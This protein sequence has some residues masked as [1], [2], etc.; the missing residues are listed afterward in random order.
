MAQPTPYDRQFSFQDFQAQ[1]PTTPLPGDEVDGELNAV[2][3][4]IDQTLVNLA[5]IQRDD[6]A[7]KNGIV[8]QDALSDSLSIGFTLRGEWQSGVNYYLGDGVTV[9]SKFFRATASALS[10]AG[11]APEQV[12]APWVVVANFTQATED[13]EAAAAAALVSEN[14]AAASAA[15]AL[16]SENAAAASADAAS[17]SA[18]A[19]AASE[20]SAADSAADAADSA[21]EAA[22]L[23]TGTVTQAVRWDVAQSLSNPEQE[24]A[25]GNIGFLTNVK[26]GLIAQVGASARARS[27]QDSYREDVTVTAQAH[28]DPTD[29]GIQQAI[30]RAIDAV[31]ARGANGGRVVIP[32][33]GSNY[34]LTGKIILKDNIILEGDGMP[35]LRLADSVNT[36]MIEGDNFLTLSGTNSGSGVDG[37]GLRNLI[38]DGNRTNNVSP[39]A[40]EGH[41]IAIYGRDFTI[42]TVEVIGAYRRGVHLEYGNTLAGVSPYNGGVFDLLVNGT[43]EEGFW[44]SV[45]DI[46]CQS[47]NLRTN[48]QN[49]DN[50]Y[51]AVYLAVGIRVTNM[52]VWMGGSSGVYHRYSLNLAGPGSTIVGAHLEAAKTAS[53]IITGAGNYLSGIDSYNLLGDDHIIVDSSRNYIRAQVFNGGQPVENINARSVR[54]INGRIGNDISVEVGGARGAV[55]AFDSVGGCSKFVANGFQAT[56]PVLFTGKPHATDTVD[57]TITGGDQASFSKKAGGSSSIAGIGSTQAGAAPINRAA[58]RLFPNGANAAFVLPPAVTGAMI[59]VSNVGG[60]GATIFPNTGDNH[61]GSAANDSVNLAAGSQAIYFAHSNTEWISIS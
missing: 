38:L 32:N 51:D 58:A 54:L 50:T 5:K 45:S 23:L 21:E 34:A 33:L 12:G 6:G 29:S 8:T 9:D 55:F 31:I 14:A 19:A 37:W 28:Y 24:Q 41:G 27:I 17:G 7:L 1:E 25:R 60:G 43:G 48:G 13:A 46:H 16:V 39:P 20:G 44:N 53:V 15:A 26:D 4:T 3:L 42:E 56:T 35:T 57:I 22:N 10:T 47:L 2:K 40:N 11:N 30:N 59:V 49:A 52:N 61:R 36:S 18:S